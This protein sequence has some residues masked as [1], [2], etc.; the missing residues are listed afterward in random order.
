MGMALRRPG[1]L[2]SAALVSC[3]AVANPGRRGALNASWHAY[4]HDYVQSDGRVI[5][6]TLGGITTSE[7]QV[8]ALLRAM[9]IGDER[10]FDAV[11]R[12]TV[13]NLQGGDPGSLPAWKWGQR[14]D[15]QWGV[16]DPS[17]AADADVLLAWVLAG[18]AVRWDR[19]ELIGR[20]RAVAG[21]AWD[22]E[23]QVIGG[24]R[25]LL[26]GPWAADMQPVWMNP[27]Y[28]MVPVFR[29]LARIDPAHPWGD[30]IDSSYA[31]LEAS[32]D[33]VTG[34]HPDW[35]FLDPETGDLV[36]PP[37]GEE[38]RAVHGFEALRVVWFLAADERWSGDARATALLDAQRPRVD[39]LRAK[40]ALPGVAA[41]DGTPAVD[42]ESRS[43]YGAMLP[44]LA[45]R[46][47]ELL[48]VLRR[49]IDD[50]AVRA[51]RGREQGRDYYAS[52]WV[53]FGEALI[54]DLGRPVELP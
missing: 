47:P 42:W 40:G 4:L 7:G 41:T 38:A 54:G 37:P 13:D 17:P 39:A 9:W 51:P 25:L 43:L 32:A 18:A 52:N 16:I 34:L 36:S 50:L 30:L 35:V 8:Y 5:D 21:R 14:D 15:G 27:S 45:L 28:L 11:L 49:R 2:V 48:P 31:L 22:A 44:T 53:W 6:Q 46:A 10:R 33:P 20:A 29:D 12:W 26:P 3:T 19:P 1:L 24:R 23:T